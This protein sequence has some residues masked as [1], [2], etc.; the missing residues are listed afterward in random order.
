MS[1][2]KFKINPYNPK[3]ITVYVVPNSLNNSAWYYKKNVS[4]KKEYN[5]IQFDLTHNPP[6]CFSFNLSFVLPGAPKYPPIKNQSWSWGTDADAVFSF[7][8]GQP[9]DGWDMNNFSVSK[10]GFIAT[11]VIDVTDSNN[12]DFYKDVDD[13]R[14][15]GLVTIDGVTTSSTSKDPKIRFNRPTPLTLEEPHQK[16]IELA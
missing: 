7:P 12:K 6:K 16:S 2:V 15:T 4:S 11:S 3:D 14:L 5:D 1:S 13:F 9:N 8:K 10:D